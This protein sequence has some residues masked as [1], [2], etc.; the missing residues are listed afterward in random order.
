MGN[1]LLILS[2]VAFEAV[3]FVIEVLL[4][5]SQ[6]T[7][8]DDEDLAL[9]ITVEEMESE[10]KKEFDDTSGCPV[11]FELFD[12]QQRIPRILPCSHTLCELCMAEI[13]NGRKFMVCPQCRKKHAA[14]SGVKAFP[15][16]KYIFKNLKPE[17]QA[18]S[19]SFDSCPEHDRELSLSCKSEGCTKDI[20]QLC[21]LQSHI[22]HKVT[23]IVEEETKRAK[24]RL[25]PVQEYVMKCK[26]IL[27]MAKQIVRSNCTATLKKIQEEKDLYVKM[28]D[29][30]MVKVSD[31]L[32]KEETEIDEQL[33]VIKEQLMKFSDIKHAIETGTRNKDVRRMV[34]TIDTIEIN[35]RDVFS[36]KSECLYYDCEEVVNG[37][38]KI[39]KV[40]P[41]LIE[42]VA[43]FNS[44]SSAP[45]EAMPTILK[46]PTQGKECVF[47]FASGSFPSFLI[48]MH[49]I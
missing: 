30:E 19:P 8:M 20:C 18:K 17:P 45:T 33:E 4:A 34:Q 26:D 49:N 22:G 15:E 29:S 27:L 1:H 32:A 13:L 42:R 35:T 14:H 47:S 7:V 5:L 6:N 12:I 44:R 39:S 46:F 23:D 10:Q 16:N 37:V 40:C 21:L 25:Q 9:A 48:A 38:D 41:R 11:C 3:S 43:L 28:F 2:N 36:R 24:S 31:R